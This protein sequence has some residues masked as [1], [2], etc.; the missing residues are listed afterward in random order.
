MI[1]RY[2]FSL[3]HILPDHAFSRVVSKR[4]RVVSELGH[5]NPTR[6]RSVDPIGAAHGAVRDIGDLVS[7]VVYSASGTIRGAYASGVE[8]VGSTYDKGQRALERFY[9]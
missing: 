7:G 2:A 6:L 5:I 4:D 9:K 8:R 1:P 3:R